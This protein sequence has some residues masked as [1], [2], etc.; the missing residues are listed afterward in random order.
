MDSQHPITSWFGNIASVGA[1]VTSWVGLLPTIMTVVASLVALIWYAIQIYESVTVQKWRR[2][3]MQARLQKLHQQASVL[4]LQLI[5]V[6][7]AATREHLKK[8]IAMRVDI[9]AGLRERELNHEHANELA[10]EAAKTYIGDREKK[11]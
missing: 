5:D 9:D 11:A 3:R 8:V 2:T 10:V 4:E 1:L 7:D 6:S